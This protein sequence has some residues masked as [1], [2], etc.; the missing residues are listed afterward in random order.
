MKLKIG[1]LFLTLTATVASAVVLRTVPVAFTITASAYV[2]NATTYNGSAATVLAPVKYSITTKSLLAQLAISEYNEGNYAFTNFPPG[3]T[4]VWLDYPDDFTQSHFVAWF[5]GG[6]LLDVSDILTA[7]YD[8]NYVTQGKFNQTSGLLNNYKNTLLFSINYDDTG[9]GGVLNYY[10]GGI[11][12]GT[13]N[14]IVAG[15]FYTE[16]WTA[17][18][19]VLQGSG[20]MGQAKFYITGSASGKGSAK[21]GL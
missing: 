20:I 14:D 10:M 16:T 12:T 2:Q 19:P 13:G 1:L 7:S 11:E 21:F 5:A 8:Q 15:L 17:S 9:A 3:T 4:L 18:A 6:V